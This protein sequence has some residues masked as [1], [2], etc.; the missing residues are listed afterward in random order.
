ML[1]QRAGIPVQS[2][3]GPFLCS[4]SSFPAAIILEVQYSGLIAPVREA[5][6]EGSTARHGLVLDDADAVSHARLGAVIRW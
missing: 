5:N 4:G 3:S 1:L 6:L 2:G